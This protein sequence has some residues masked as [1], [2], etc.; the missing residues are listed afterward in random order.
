MILKLLPMGIS[1]KTP[2]C[3]IPMLSTFN[4]WTSMLRQKYYSSGE[5]TKYS[6]ISL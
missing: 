3:E 2:G 4:W 5:D 1:T 6:V